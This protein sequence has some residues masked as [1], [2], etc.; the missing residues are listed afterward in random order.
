M[1]TLST[2]TF[3]LTIVF[4]TNALG[5]EENTKHTLRLVADAKPEPANIEDFAWLQGYWTG[6]GLGGECEEMWSAPVA[7]AMVGTFR[8]MNEG[9]LQFSEFFVLAESK[10][11]ISLK[12]KHFDDKLHGWEEKD[13]FVEFKFIKA[14][15]KTAWFEGLTYQL[16]EAG[17]LHVYVA[18][19]QKDGTSSEGEF[20]FTRGS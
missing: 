11:E 18:M 8:M 20:T 9:A 7:G 15:Q 19:K 2:I 13:K 14:E 17:T 12:L 1:N 4:T 10:G 3:A 5:Q 16:D 6:S